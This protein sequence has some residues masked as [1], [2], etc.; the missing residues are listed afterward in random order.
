VPGVHAVRSEHLPPA[1]DLSETDAGLLRR[2]AAGERAAFDEFVRRHQAAALRLLTATAVT[3]ADAEDALQE[4]FIAAWRSAAGFAGTGSARGWMLTIAR[5]ALHRRYR[6][7]VGE[8][9]GF[10]PLDALGVAAGWGAEEPP[11]V[12]LERLEDRERL[13]RALDSLPKPDREVLILRDLEELSGEETAR[14]LGVSLRAMKSRLHRARLRLAA[15]VRGE[16]DA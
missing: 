3:A 8:P 5:H 15:L 11:D 7:R 6:R 13:R 4:A 16:T 1:E 14:V 2:T 12:L 9:E 10:E